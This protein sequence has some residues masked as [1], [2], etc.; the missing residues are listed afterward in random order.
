MRLHPFSSRL[1]TL[2]LLPLQ[3]LLSSPHFLLL[4]QWSALLNKN[5]H[6]PCATAPLL[7]LPHPAD[8]SAA[9]PFPHSEL[10]KKINSASVSCLAGCSESLRELVVCPVLWKGQWQVLPT[11]PGLRKLCLV[12]CK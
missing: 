2:L 11:L 12:H 6:D 8:A 10:N 7:I 5:A 3:L 9:A 1:L 4:S